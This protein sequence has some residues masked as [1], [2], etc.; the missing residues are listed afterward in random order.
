[1]IRLPAAPAPIGT[2]DVWDFSA[3]TVAFHAWNPFQ[4]FQIADLA[5]SYKDSVLLLE[6]R[7]NMDFDRVFDKTVLGELG[8]P[9]IE[10]TARRIAASDGRFSA[11]VCQTPF[12]HIERLRKTKRIAMQYSMTKEGHQYGAWR[13]MFDLNL[14]YGEYSRAH[15][16]P[17]SPCR[18]IGNPRFE[19]WFDGTLDQRK[20]ERA[21]AHLDPSKKTI[22][23]LPTWGELSS[24]PVYQSA[25]GKLTEKYNVIAKVHHNTDALELKQKVALGK[26]GLN[27]IFGASDDLL[28]LLA[29][30]DMVLSDYSGAIFDAVNVRKPVVLLQN[31]P[32]KLTGQKFGLESIEYA[33][34]HE[35][36]PIADDPENLAATIEDAFERP[37]RFAEVNSALKSECFGLET[38]CGAAGAEAISDLLSGR[39]APRAYYQ[40]Y[41]RDEL[42]RNREQIEKYKKLIPSN[43]NANP[44]RLLRIARIIAGGG[45]RI[46]ARPAAIVAAPGPMEDTAS[47]QELPPFL[48]SAFKLLPS[49]LLFL[50]AKS[51][52]KQGRETA[53][54]QTA[55]IAALRGN[56]WALDTVTLAA[57]RQK[58]TRLLKKLLELFGRLPQRSFALSAWNAA[59]TCEALGIAGAGDYLERSR[60]ILM[61]DIADRN[62][63]V[64]TRRRSLKALVQ[65]RFWRD[66][67]DLLPL[68]GKPAIRAEIQADIDGLRARSRNWSDLVELANRNARK[69]GAW[70]KRQGMVSRLEDVD[71]GPVIEFLVPTY[72]ADMPSGPDAAAHAR[73]CTFLRA[74]LDELDRQGFSIVPRHQFWLN[75]ANPSGS[76]PALSYHTTGDRPRWLH[77]KDSAV[78]G[79]YR[80]DAQGYAGFSVLALLTELPKIARDASPEAVE[81]TWDQIREATIGQRLSKYAQPPATSLPKGDYLFF[82]L[83]L[84]EDTV[85]GLAWIPMLEAVETVIET[86]APTGMSLVLKRHPLCKSS[87]VKAALARFSRSPRVLVSDGSIHDILPRARSVVTVNSGV[88]LEALLHGR[89]VI[90]VGQSEYGVAT[91]RC[92]T[93]AELREALAA[94]H[95]VSMDVIKRFV[96]LYASNSVR[97]DD[98]SPITEWALQN[99]PV[100]PAT[101]ES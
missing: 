82:P 84:L 58:H 25:L 24:V 83:Q 14:V 91:T 71:G 54:V 31:Q 11:I 22:L 36:G 33:R 100:A 78:P 35:I 18:I 62:L 69:D 48:R 15:I 65:Q 7:V 53:A 4:V 1:M 28:Y 96:W 63:P 23:Y 41:V 16:A 93:K 27:S 50:A 64:K 49:A 17:L 99:Q 67:E 90:T 73:I 70:C 51:M 74:V 34:R 5:R 10:T 21:K 6:H 81:A 29:C 56:E 12:R 26:S 101:I 77:L 20:L 87:E 60:Q 92:R 43:I 85:S 79:Y 32:E 9:V 76:W 97:P 45:F 55:E 89:H 80:F 86:L 94:P 40:I 59:R 2:S 30:S 46:L 39:T 13:A 68:I 44:R 19:P 3:L 38:G 37:D 75:I 72:F 52:L 42:L 57:G 61:T 47:D 95:P 98:L 88:G 8:L 66:A